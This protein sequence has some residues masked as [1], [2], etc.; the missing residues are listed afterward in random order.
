MIKNASNRQWQ[1][2][3]GMRNHKRRTINN[4]IQKHNI[5]WTNK[6]EGKPEIKEDISVIEEEAIK[7]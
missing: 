4:H 1:S 7:Y 2:E 5:A 6:N 3:Q